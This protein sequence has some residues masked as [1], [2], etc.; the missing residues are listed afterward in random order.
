MIE[1]DFNTSIVVPGTL[2]CVINGLNSRGDFVGECLLE[3]ETVA[4]FC[5]ID[6]GFTILQ[7]PKALSTHALGISASNEVFGDYQFKKDRYRGFRW[8]DGSFEDVIIEEATN[9]FITSANAPGDF[10]GTISKDG[11]RF[12]FAHIGGDVSI[13]DD[14]NIEESCFF[15]IADSGHHVGYEVFEVQKTAVVQS[16]VSTAEG[17]IEAI[18]FPVEEEIQMYP[19]GINGID[20]SIIG[21]KSTTDEPFDFEKPRGFLFRDGTLHEFFVPS[22]LYSAPRAINSVG[23]IVGYFIDQE[24]KK[25]AFIATPS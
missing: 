25:R 17:E 9:T 5:C 22:A 3:G 19:Y 1:F 13:Y 6:S 11:S 21:L 18:Q 20:G 23:T 14:E 4:G 12:G 10:V 7:V 8:K 2:G 15:G 16:I 24:H